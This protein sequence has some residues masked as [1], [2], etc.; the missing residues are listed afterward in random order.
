MILKVAAARFGYLNQPRLLMYSA[1]LAILAAIAGITDYGPLAK[2]WL[3]IS[4]LLFVAA[5]AVGIRAT[6]LI[7]KLYGGQEREIVL[8]ADGVTIREPGMTTSYAWS[9]F[10]R[11]LDRGDHIVLV[12]R[13][14]FVVVLQRAFDPDTFARV[15][16]LV[17]AKVPERAHR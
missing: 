3:A 6:R 2:L 9:R 5:S 16:A 8:D 13:A 11:A 14:N 7:G 4:I 12:T 15:R 1:V 10:E 17:G